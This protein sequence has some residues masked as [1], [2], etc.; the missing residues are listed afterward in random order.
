MFVC[1]TIL[2]DSII[3]PCLVLGFG[4]TVGGSSEALG[5]LGESDLQD[6]FR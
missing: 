1:W 6:L 5:Q 4:R 2:F 3:I